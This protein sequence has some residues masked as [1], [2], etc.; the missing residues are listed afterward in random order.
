[1]I[2]FHSKDSI[3]VDTAL[4]HPYVKDFHGQMIEPTFLVL[5]DFSAFEGD[6][7]IANG[8]KAEI[9]NLLYAEVNIY[10]K[11]LLEKK[12][13]IAAEERTIEEATI[14]QDRT[15]ALISND[16]GVQDNSI[17][18]KLPDEAAS[19]NF[20]ANPDLKA[21]TIVPASFA[22]EVGVAP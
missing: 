15:E 17:I 8:D 22:N 4:E 21:D 1:M 5:F 12:A 19:S 16:V 10:T 9:Q 2:Q 11:R 20:A 13:T 14:T 6:E 7:E 3:T 18:K